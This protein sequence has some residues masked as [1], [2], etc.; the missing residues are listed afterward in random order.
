MTYSPDGTPSRRNLVG[1]DVTEHVRRL[2]IHR[3]E[4]SFDVSRI[5]VQRD[6]A[7]ERVRELE[8]AARRLLIASN[9]GRDAIGHVLELILGSTPDALSAEIAA[10]RW[11]ESSKV[12]EE[13]GAA[14]ADLE[15][16]LG[17]GGNVAGWAEESRKIDAIVNEA[18]RSDV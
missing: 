1:L 7:F 2:E 16:V 12:F 15:R 3:N 18:R 13:R 5:S 14:A 10:K 9:A 4:L 8:A 6:A 11:R 17:T